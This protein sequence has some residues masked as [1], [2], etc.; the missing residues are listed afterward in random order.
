MEASESGLTG[1][2]IPKSTAAPQGRWYCHAGRVEA[3]GFPYRHTLHPGLR[4][5]E[6]RSTWLC[7]VPALDPWEP[8]DRGTD[9][10]PA[11]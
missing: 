5:G 1:H 10:G 8:G 6:A 2:I 3:L 4:L 11:A 9:T 7:R